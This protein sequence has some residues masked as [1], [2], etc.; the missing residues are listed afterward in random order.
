MSGKQ[1]VPSGSE[2]SMDKNKSC[3][4]LEQVFCGIVAMILD[5][6]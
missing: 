3:V 2:D 4:L 1:P 5:T 6:L